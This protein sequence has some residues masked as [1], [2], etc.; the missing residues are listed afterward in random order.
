MYSLFHHDVHVNEVFIL[1]FEEAHL[2]QVPPLKG[3]H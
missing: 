2:N 3:P 1:F